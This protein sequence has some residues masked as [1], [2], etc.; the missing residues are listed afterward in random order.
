[1]TASGECSKK[2]T[3]SNFRKLESGSVKIDPTRGRALQ[4]GICLFAAGTASESDVNRRQPH[5]K[6]DDETLSSNTRPSS[7]DCFGDRTLT[8]M[9]TITTINFV[10]ITITTNDTTE[11]PRM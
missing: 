3:P 2:K 6:V 8:K 7:S 5:D 1:M 10:T 4:P 11:L 9:V